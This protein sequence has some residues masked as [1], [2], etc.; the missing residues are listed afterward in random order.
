MYR[1]LLIILIAPAVAFAQVQM[2]A[3]IPQSIRVEREISIEELQNL[4]MTSHPTLSKMQFMVRAA[5]GTWVQSGLGPNPEL[6]VDFI[7]LGNEHLNGQREIGITQEIV[8]NG[9]LRLSR[10]VAKTEWDISQKELAAQCISLTSLVKIR[11][12][13]LLAA[14]KYVALQQQLLKYR[15]ESV[16][17]SEKM[18]EAKEVSLVDVVQTRTLRNETNLALKKAIN[19]EAL[20][21]QRLTATIGQPDF[22]R[23]R[24][25]NTLEE[26]DRDLQW[27]TAWSNLLASSPELQLAQNNVELAYAVLRREKAERRPNLAVSAT[28]GYDTRSVNSYGTVGVSVPLQLRNRNQGN[29]Q[30]ATADLSAANC[31]IEMV[32]LRLQEKLSTVFNQY[33]NAKQSV[34]S[35][36]QTILPDTQMNLDLCMKGYQ[37]GEFSYL[38]LLHIQQSYIESQQQYIQ[39]LRDLAVSGTQIEGLLTAETDN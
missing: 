36:L 10:Q 32:K 7:E 29:I 24:I 8:T 19:D 28:M 6:N 13:E 33:L 18:H 9:K 23:C 38:E 25:A 2:P 21:W 31:E 5:R 4:A 14:Q 15:D 16:H 26:I 1:S 17:I 35:Y 39:N 20:C 3:P 11:V 30:K 22:P 34:D 27:E 37:Q 12:Y